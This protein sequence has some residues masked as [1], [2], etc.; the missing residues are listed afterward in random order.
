MPSLVG[1]WGSPLKNMKVNWDDYSQYMGKKNVPNHQP[2]LISYPS[3]KLLHPQNGE[4]LFW[5]SSKSTQDFN[6][7]WKMDWFKGNENKRHPV[8]LSRFHGKIQGFLA[9]FASTNAMLLHQLPADLGAPNHHP[10]PPNTPGLKIFFRKI[11]KLETELFGI[12]SSL[13]VSHSRTKYRGSNWKYATSIQR[14]DAYMFVPYQVG[15]SYPRSAPHEIRSNQ[16][17]ENPSSKGHRSNRSTTGPFFGPFP[18][19]SILHCQSCQYPA[20]TNI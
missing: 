1:G 16:S 15:D 8:F 9:I 18:S 2:V 13:W 3:L 7:R 4:H 10:R 14:F 11:I 19:A 12:C 17:H 5:V 20:T 6:G